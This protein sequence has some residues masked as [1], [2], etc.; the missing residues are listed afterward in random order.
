MIQEW[1]Q[2]G[3]SG[4]MIGLAGAGIAVSLITWLLGIAMKRART[5]LRLTCTL[6][7]LAILA[8]LPLLVNLS[9]NSN[10][11]TIESKPIQLIPPEAKYDQQFIQAVE[12]GKPT[13]GIPVSGGFIETMS[14]TPRLSILIGS[15]WLGASGMTLLIVFIRRW[16]LRRWLATHATV[17]GPDL[18][19]AEVAAPFCGAILRPFIVV[20]HDFVDLSEQEQQAILAH[21]RA[22]LRYHHSVQLGVAETASAIFGWIPF[23]HLIRRQLDYLHE[24]Q[25]DEAVVRQGGDGLALARSLVRFAERIHLQTRLQ[26]T[27]SMIR[28]KLTLQDRV[29]RLTQQGGLPMQPKKTTLALAGIA[30]FGLS[31]A[32]AVS[33][34]VRSNPVEETKRFL[35]YQP[36][37]VWTYRYTRN[38]GQSGE[39]RVKATSLQAN[40]PHH[41][42]EFVRAQDNYTAYDYWM[43]TPDGLIPVDNRS[44]IGP[45]FSLHRKRGTHL[46]LNVKAGHK[47]SWQ[48]EF[49]GQ[50]ASGPDGGVPAPPPPIDLEGL[51]IDLDRRVRVPFGTV[52]ATVIDIKTIGAHSWIERSYWARNVGL[53][54][55]EFLDDKGKITQTEELVSVRVE[56]G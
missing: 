41:V 27:L 45:G 2:P 26:S 46:P 17:L 22:H 32:L 52:T 20:P 7:G 11:G 23:V 3:L 28:A 40:K 31:A 30:M 50:I 8:A 34:Q 48:E 10:L 21:E 29:E 6:S 4:Y 42:M 44:M 33:M 12:S 43:A 39:I 51:V 38:D 16:L 36:G 9:I 55:R 47:W 15:F 5:E 14:Y 1:L 19:R 25:C 37:K 56:K 18:F 54:K 49:R 24:R 13:D 53:V 35:P